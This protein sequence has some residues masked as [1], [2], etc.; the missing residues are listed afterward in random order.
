VSAPLPPGSLAFR[1]LTLGYD[2]HPAVHHLDGTVPAGATLAVVGP[3]GAG[4]STLLKGL[5]GEIPPLE[6]RI[7]HPGLDRKG[8]AYLPQA[9]E[10][11]RGFPIG[12]H[13]FVG[14]GLWRRIG[15]WGALRP[16][17]ARV[18]EALDTVGLAGFE[19]RPIGTLSG[20][21][22]RRAMFARV[23][24][25]DA[26]VILLDEPFAAVDARTTEDLLGLTRRWQAEA[27]TVVAVLHDL[28]QVRRHFPTTLLLAR[29][30]VAWGPTEAVL[31]QPNLSRARRLCE[32]WD[33]DA[34]VCRGPA[35]PHAHEHG[36]SHG[37]SH[38][39]DHEHAA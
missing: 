35:E 12:V 21:Q 8:F 34:P 22:L 15:P 2:R 1:G 32:A 27:R 38:P 29:E 36:P 16:H 9:A 10:I 17:R 25:Q 11:D 6:G 28:D 31:T 23:L 30:A 39:H 13:D 14:M 3:N 26:R 7:L 37:P 19:R 33:D 4:K 5:M 24:L 18:A 20:G